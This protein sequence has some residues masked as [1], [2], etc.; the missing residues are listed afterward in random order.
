MKTSKALTMIVLAIMLVMA[1]SCKKDKSQSDLTEQ[2][3]GSY[4]GTLT[5]GTVKS[6][7]SEATADVSRYNDYTVQIHCYGSE[8]DTT[9][10]LE[11][12]ENG[13]TMMVCFTGNDF[14]REYGHNM[15]ENHHMMGENGN[16]T[17]WGQHMSYDHNPNDKHYGNFNMNNHM[18]EY[19]FNMHNDTGDYTLYFS[20]SRQ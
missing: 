3:T 11:L 8:L 12:Y 1:I 7:S 19:T 20:G 10:M 4:K 17:N 14:Y 16:W 2:V 9:F 6:V 15:S 5:P 18:F 13:S